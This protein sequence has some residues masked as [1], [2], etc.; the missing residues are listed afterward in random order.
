MD[1]RWD[2]IVVGG[3]TAGLFAGIASARQGARTLLIERSGRLGGNI[4][5]GMTLGGC[6]D[7][8]ERQVIRGLPEELIARVV[9]RGGGFGHRFS[10]S[11]DR[12][13]S[14]VASVDPEMFQ[15]VVWD[16]LEECGC[17]TWLFTPLIRGLR[18]GSTV[19]A[20]EV[21]TWRRLGPGKPVSVAVRAWQ[22]GY[23]PIALGSGERVQENRSG[24]RFPQGSPPGAM[25]RK[26]WCL[27][28]WV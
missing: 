24:P 12:S 21:L 20:I 6:F 5:T 19:R 28:D 14:S 26:E 27:R 9:A 11:G 16:L 8:A 15:T 3:G 23:R 1:E 17:S 25:N 2:V 4:A 7:G 22:G 10:R 13:M 18:E